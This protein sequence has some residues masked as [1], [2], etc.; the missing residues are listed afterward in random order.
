MGCEDG[1][2]TWREKDMVLLFCVL[3]LEKKGLVE[4]DMGESRAE[5]QS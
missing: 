5:F 2:A 3:N 4:A 1:H